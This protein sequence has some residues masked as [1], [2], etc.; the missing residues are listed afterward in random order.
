MKLQC[1]IGSRGKFVRL[2]SGSLGVLVGIVLSSF[3]FISGAELST[4][5]I[6]PASLIG[7]GAFAIFE[8]WSG[9]CVA[10][11]LG[12]WTPI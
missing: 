1:N 10:R 5:W 4:L 9:W 12:F 7:G 2:V 8:G 6:A 11:A 3:L